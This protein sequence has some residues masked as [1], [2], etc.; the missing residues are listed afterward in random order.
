MNEH[1]RSMSSLCQPCFVGYDFIGKMDSLIEDSNMLLDYLE[2]NETIRF[3]NFHNYTRY[4][5]SIKDISKKFYSTVS[6]EKIKKLYDEVYRDDFE[7]F[8]YDIPSYINDIILE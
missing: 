2:V 3:T 1:W 7:A 5:V 6:N 8:D 4:N